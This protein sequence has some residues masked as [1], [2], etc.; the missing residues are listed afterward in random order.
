MTQRGLPDNSRGARCI[1]KEFVA[2]K[3]LYCHAPPGFNQEEFHP[4]P[5]RIKAVS[6]RQP[7]QLRVVRVSVQ[8][9]TLFI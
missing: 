1:L 7:P 6:D 4:F 9:S 5:A 8:I 3:L 2:G